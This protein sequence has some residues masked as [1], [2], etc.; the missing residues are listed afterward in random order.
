MT[1]YTLQQAL[2]VRASVFDKAYKDVVL[3]LT[4]LADNNIDPDRFF[5]ENYITRGMGQLYQAVFGRLEGTNPDGIFKLTQ[6]MGGGKTHSMIAVGL[7][8]KY[9]EYRLQVMGE[10]YKSTFKGAAKVVTFSG[11]NRPE[12]GIWGHIAEQL[13]KSEVFSHLYK[14]SEAPGQSEWIKLLQGDP[15][16]LLIDEL[17]DYLGYASTVQ[18][19]LGS[20]A[21]KTGRAL[22]TLLTAI[23]KDEL[24]NVVL[25]LSD[26]TGSHE[27]GSS[28]IASVLA[29]FEKETRR[30]AKNFT[31]VQQNT[32]EIYHIL[33]KRLFENEA[34][35]HQIAEVAKA[36]REALDRAN[37]MDLTNES[38]SKMEAAIQES[39]PFHP[40]IRPL[41]ERF[42]ENDGF[43]QTRGLIRLMRT[44]VSRMYDPEAGFAHER[45]LIHPYDIDPNDSDTVTE[46][47]NIN[48]K[49]F[50][51]ISHDI[52]SGGQAAAEKLSEELA[53]DL[54]SR[55]AKL[56]FIASLN[57][58]PNGL[59]GL[60]QNE[61][62]AFLAAPGVEVSALGS[63]VLPKLRENSW[64]L[65]ADKTGSLLYKDVQN[66]SAKIS[67][68][69]KNLTRESLTKEIRKRLEELFVPQMKD[70]YQELAVLPAVGD[71]EERKDKITLVIYYP[72]QGGSLHPDLQ[73]KYD[74]TRYKN[75]LLFLTG[76]HPSMDTIYENARSILAT[77][78]VIAEMDSDKVP[79]SDPQ[80]QE[81]QN[82]RENYQLYFR[83]A[84][85]N[86]FTKLF[87]PSH[88][89]LVEVNI[90][91]TFDKNRYDGEAQ[92]R[93]TLEAKNKFTTHLAA[94]SFIMQ[95]EQKL[96]SGQKQRPWNDVVEA[97]A[98][99][100]SWVWYKPN[101]LDQVKA[102][103]FQKDLWRED[104]NWVRIG[105]FE[106]PST[107]VLVKDQGVN[108][109][110]GKRQL[111]IEA[112]RGT[113]VFYEYGT[114][115]ST[116]SPEW[117]TRKLLETDEM[118]IAFLC[119]DEE[120]AHP[121]GDP[122]QWTN[123]I[124]LKYDYAQQGDAFL[125][126]FQVTPLQAEIRYS[127]DGSNP[128]NGGIY[129][130]PFLAKP[131]TK[132]LAVA[133][134]AGIQSPQV[135][136][137]LPKAN[138]TSEAID[139]GKALRYRARFSRPTTS[140]TYQALGL[141]KKHQ[142]QLEGPELQ[143][144][145]EGQQYVVIQASPG[146]YFPAEA[147]EQH[148]RY[149]QDHLLPQGD[150]SLKAKCLQF[151]TGQHFLDFA[152]ESGLTFKPGDCE[153]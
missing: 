153:Q 134:K 60:K 15:V 63:T 110:T 149:L 46:L 119:V 39:Y 54:P 38:A 101:G 26:L 10:V 122:F 105:P 65:H 100:P 108:P 139:K 44:L 58:T 2:T 48:G 114:K 69:R 104:G 35:D 61:I 140:E 66:V 64:Y 6:A 103:Q 25:V 125:V 91:L 78:E 40:A 24:S 90:N 148:L 76:D 9:P 31:P 92:I 128:A 22:T 5:A 129:S 59:K 94:S 126:S 124:E 80:Y 85:T 131:Q 120:G 28:R 45:Y 84:A 82:M 12:N 107:E 111:K 117:D 49:L 116:D 109:D 143:A 23:S 71:I 53:N 20:L 145:G 68:Y 86:V 19:G 55:A 77:R 11:R 70:L 99:D 138:D 14:R 133:T 88:R 43:M 150:I 97:A 83:S 16:V 33:R 47:N 34:S 115:V 72:Y 130:A 136:F 137:D 113:T 144:K 67:T 42:R 27:K 32:T 147:V 152:R 123:T 98:T 127:T 37:R 151:A 62:V 106:K 50:N 135:N 41:Y 95:L 57:A 132:I 102:E 121:T 30:T 112:L 8:A 7:L 87:Y 81:A 13:G 18:F 141:L 51:A 29:D 93:K 74:N 96:F 73:E 36:Y 75:R 56:V 21:E 52:A 118:H 17:P 142:A 4:D 146:L 3:D 89:G 1:M 79:T